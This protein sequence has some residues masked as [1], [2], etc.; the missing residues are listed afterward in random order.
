MC[1]YL[2]GEIS[3]LQS[4]GLATVGE[5]EAVVTFRGEHAVLEALLGDRQVRG[6]E[7][8]RR[9]R[10]RHGQLLA[11]CLRCHTDRKWIMQVYTRALRKT[12]HGRGGPRLF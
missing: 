9:V 5:V 11:L 1:P 8:D 3:D 12:G 10:D 2:V 4:V 6:R 7:A